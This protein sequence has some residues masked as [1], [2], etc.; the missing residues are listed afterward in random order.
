[1]N[2]RDAAG[3]DFMVSVMRHLFGALATCAALC[4][5]PATAQEGGSG[6]TI[7]TAMLDDAAFGRVSI[8]DIVAR[9]AAPRPGPDLNVLKQ[10]VEAYRSGDVAEGDR[11]RTGMEDLAARSLL[12][13][14]AIRTNA[15]LGFDRIVRFMQDDPS[16]PVG[17]LIRRRAEEALLTNRKPPAVVRAFFATQRPISAAGRFAL[18]VAFQA[19]GLERDAAVLIRETW[20]KDLFGREFEAKIL[21]KFPTAL[22]QADHRFRMERLLFKENWEAA[23]RAAGYAGKDYAALVKARIAVNGSEKKAAALLEAVP[24]SL[25]SDTSYAFSRAQFLRRNNKPLEA[26]KAMT[27]VTRDPAI[28]ADGD[29][30]W[31]ERRIV[32]RKL[33]DEGNASAAYEVVRNHGADGTAQ[34][35]EA[36]FHAG[37]IALR[38]LREPALAAVHFREAARIA[39]TP[40]SIARAA[41]WQGRTA[42][43][44]GADGV[45]RRYYER[46]AAYPVT[47]YGQLSRA[48]LGDAIAL[49]AVPEA[50]VDSNREAF[51][52]LTA[53]KALRLLY[54]LGANNLA[55]PLYADLSQNL[56]DP[57]QLQALG[58][59]AA[60]N[61]DARGL[62]MVGKTAVQRGF[63]LD[64][65][66]YPTIG[67]PAFEPVGGRSD[68]AMVYAIARQE[69]AFDPAAQ[70][71]A[72]A[73]G[74]MQLMPATAKR[75][76]QRFGLGFDVNKLTADPAYNAKLGSAHLGELMQDWKNSLILT[77]AS[78]NAGGG[79]VKKWI[80]AYGDPRQAHV[81]AV[82]WIER[83]PFSETR[84][85][86][87][88][89]LE[90]LRVYRHRLGDRN[91]S[92]GDLRQTALVR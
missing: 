61:G 16:W 59:L 39:E 3:V 82:D 69:S 15:R 9:D 27:D 49:R 55:L 10:A 87:Q 74:L 62:L 8:G 63:P 38:F 81:D 68:K 78:Y 23:R 11:L 88:R 13:W 33:L 36:E 53:P 22:T 19:D 4:S 18:A 83:I 84:N 34:R 32:A 43:E 80:G 57:A 90:N 65:H 24:P 52:R 85:Y 91:M 6:P 47:Y 44:V 48:K 76:A 64:V 14:V 66:A 71:G 60:E 89:V 7:V 26:A 72:G 92:E 86:V 79:N 54:G 46:G 56:K 25:R 58:D 12:E 17:G 70:S 28:L 30:W 77:I 45:A 31:S 73:R 20:R 67:I 40:I 50:A 37:W 5:G 21:E 51:A 1:M 42:E 35:I 29:E 75:T 41:Y 2:G